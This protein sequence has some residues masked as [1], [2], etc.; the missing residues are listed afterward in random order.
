LADDFWLDESFSCFAV[1]SFF[2]RLLGVGTGLAETGT[3]AVATLAQAKQHSSSKM[4]GRVRRVNMGGSFDKTPIKPPVMFSRE[5]VLA[6]NPPS[7][8]GCVS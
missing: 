7:N 5:S 6:A 4:L 3:A 1:L 8:R 2:E